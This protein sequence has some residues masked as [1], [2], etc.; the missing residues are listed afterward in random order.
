[1]DDEMKTVAGKSEAFFDIL[2][3]LIGYRRGT[4]Q[5]AY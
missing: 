5:I 2:L 3:N 1:M 4:D